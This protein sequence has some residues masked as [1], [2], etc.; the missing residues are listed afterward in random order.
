MELL[1][2]LGGLVG[3]AFYIDH[4]DSDD[5]GPDSPPPPPPDRFDLIVDGTDGADSLRGDTGD[6]LVRGLD[7]DD[8]ISGYDGDD[9][10]YGGAGNDI[11]DRNA[12]EDTIFGGAGNDTIMEARVPFYDGPN[13]SVI[14]GGSGDDTIGF[15]GGSTVTG[16]AGADALA[17]FHNQQDDAPSV[18]TDFDA[19]QD[20]LTVFLDGV[21]ASAGSS[22]RLEDWADGQGANLYYGDELLARINGGQG[23]DP[24]AI[25][26]RVS[27]AENGGNVSFA[28]GNGD[29]TIFGNA[30]NDT[31]FGQGGDDLII[32]G[33]TP[34]FGG[35]PAQ[36][37]ENLA[38]GGDGS[39][40][41][42]GSGGTFASF[43]TGGSGDGRP[44]SITYE[45]EIS[46]DTLFGG[47]GDDYLLSENGNDLTG[48]AGA[49]VFAISHL[50]GDAAVGFTLE[51][52]VITD[53]NPALDSIVLTSGSV[54]TGAALT[55]S[56]W[57]NGLGSDISAG[58]TVIA[59]VTGGQT[60]RVGDIRMESNLVDAY[61]NA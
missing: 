1:L 61:L 10:L 45:Q 41:L 9:A 26:L 11:F 6:D 49:D 14:D 20:S 24:A 31:I 53:F 52:T 47:G 21:Q 29:T 50:T 7:G 48:G 38:Y 39:D 46:R 44:I 4:K 13:I 43:Q 8:L 40:T 35:S 54:P 16:G 58:T 34:S 25:D 3:L 27:L 15:D 55:I 51:P 36:G 37:G 60:L 59:K 17:L 2:L 57:A 42:A 30:A 12:G 23:L 33:N 5:A 56:V 32:V 18:I 19:A 22:V 28:D